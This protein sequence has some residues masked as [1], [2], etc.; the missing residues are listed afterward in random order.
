MIF[1]AFGDFSDFGFATDPVVG[2]G[3]VEPSIASMTLSSA[4]SRTLASAFSIFVGGDGICGACGVILIS[5]FFEL[6]ERAYHG[7]FTT[8]TRTMIPNKITDP[9]TAQPSPFTN[10]LVLGGV[11]SAELQQ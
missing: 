10:Q 7:I 6:S 4:F 11:V 8:M 5:P 9:A 2:V 3:S 1:A